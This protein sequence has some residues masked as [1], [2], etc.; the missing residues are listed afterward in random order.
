MKL[1]AMADAYVDRVDGWDP[2]EEAA[3]R[4]VLKSFLQEHGRQT[5]TTV[6][7]ELTT[8]TRDPNGQLTGSVKWPIII[9]GD[10]GS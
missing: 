9:A 2:R 1:A 10:S 5:S 8:V 3:A 7:G 6:K 4:A